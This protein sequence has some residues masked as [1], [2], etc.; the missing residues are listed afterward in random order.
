VQTGSA[1]PTLAVITMVYNEVDFLP[2]WLR[3]YGRVAGP[4]NC[5]VVDHGSDDGSTAA[6]GP[7]SVIR[8]PRS[9]LDDTK[10]T[11]AMGDLVASLL[12][13]YDFVAY[14]DVDEL[15]VADPAIFP[16]LRQYCAAARHDTM[17]AFGMNVIHR[18]H[19]EPALRY[20]QPISLQRRSLL[21]LSSMA[22]PL[23]T[24]MPVRW[25]PGFHT[26]NGPP[27]F[28]GLFNFHLSYVDQERML[29]RQAK[30]R[31]SPIAG[32]PDPKV[33]HHL[34]SDDATL[35]LLENWTQFSEQTDVTLTDSCARYRAFASEILA[36]YEL[37]KNHEYRINMNLWNNV[38]WRLP[39][40]F[41]GTF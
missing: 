12:R 13:W 32:T 5:F 28:D 8:I 10:R 19:S 24:R 40:R 4:E 36:S 7:A 11:A 17:T 9:P 2:L 33:H 26:Y 3:H 20:D 27:V 29:R 6:I 30:R 1:L 31:G 22:K 37:Y 18:F 34:F 21:A 16:T 23:L 14:T 15:L 25:S 35:H 41:V 38:L 39:D